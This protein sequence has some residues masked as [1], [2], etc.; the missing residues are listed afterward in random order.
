MGRD[1]SMQ[2]MCG[3]PVRA[4]I[5]DVCDVRGRSWGDWALMLVVGHLYEAE[6]SSYLE[7]SRPRSH[8]SISK[9]QVQP[10]FSQV[11]KFQDAPA[12]RMKTIP[13]DS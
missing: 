12:L 7:L 2:S 3:A 8:A 11:Q 5:E 9:A 1:V 6:T 10:K 13:L 4:P